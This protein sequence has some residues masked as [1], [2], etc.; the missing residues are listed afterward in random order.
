MKQVAWDTA[1]R[2]G[3]LE[4]FH[5]VPF[6]T[7]IWEWQFEQ[8]PFGKAFTPVVFVDDD[9][10][11]IG[12]NGVV[13]VNASDHGQP[14][15]A[16]WSC[17]FY[18]AT[19]WRGKGLGSKIKAALHK[20]CDD[21]ITL[22]VSD[23]AA[24]V[25]AHLGWKP[26]H[27]V[28]NYRLLRR[29]DSL[30]QWGLWLFQWLNRV[31]YSDYRRDRKYDC[32]V[33]STLPN[34]ADLDR[35]WDRSRQNLGKAVT[36]NFDYLDWKYQ[37]HPLARY[38]F[39]Q[40]RLNGALAG[41]LVVRFHGGVLRIV[42]FCGRDHDSGLIGALIYR[43]RLNWRNARQ[44][45]TVT[46]SKTLGRCLC[47]QGFFRALSRPRFFEYQKGVE[48]GGSES[49]WFLMSGDS[50]GEQLAAAADACTG[51]SCHL[52]EPGSQTSSDL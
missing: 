39:V 35:L 31:R 29:P 3:V 11:V 25:L 32:I 6:K 10:R 8:N 2:Q 49:T 1:Y 18:V 47:Q 23:K 38:A 26:Y 45:T 20:Q 51:G 34:K 22:G 14:I 21:I 4:L 48:S 5:D 36:R 44:L 40:A 19:E 30:R 43:C 46:S 7:L 16:L 28:F 27:S 24:Q 12:F 17:D 15:D 33:S 42:D 37:R 13:A 9:D 50:D 41:L 52:R